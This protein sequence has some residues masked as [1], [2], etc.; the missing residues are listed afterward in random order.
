MCYFNYAGLSHVRAG[1]RHGSL[2]DEE[3]TD[4]SSRV[5]V[6]FTLHSF[7]AP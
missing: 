4:P 2:R 1:G 7:L 6:P 3:T 5:R